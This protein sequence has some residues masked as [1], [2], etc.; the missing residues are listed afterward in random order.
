MID[1]EEQI[2]Y[3]KAEPFLD[4]RHLWRRFK[5]GSE[6]AFIKIYESYFDVLLNYGYQLTGREDLTQDAIQDL[7]IDI[8]DSRE[9]LGDTHSIKFYLMKSLKRKLFRESA[10]WYNQCDTIAEGLPFEVT[11]S[12]EKILIDRQISEE[13]SLKLNQ[14]VQNMPG[15]KK[16]ALY[17]FYYEG[18]S[19]EQIKEMM[20]LSHIKS[21]R[22]LVYEAISY[23]REA[24]K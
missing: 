12:H 3:E 19:Y 4:D 10:R 2:R 9:R 18:L 6:S 7:F 23:L 22:N 15:R 21:A 1:F 24:L 16:E 20:E 5:S 14:A 17:Y 8:R 13:Q 11:F